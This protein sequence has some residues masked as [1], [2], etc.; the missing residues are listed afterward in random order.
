MAWLNLAVEQ[1]LQAL[2]LF[3]EGEDVA[4]HSIHLVFDC[5]EGQ[6]H[7]GAGAREPV[8]N[9]FKFFEEGVCHHGLAHIPKRPPENTCV[10]TEL[11]L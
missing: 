10:S 8:A 9:D 4:L 7:P 11:M 2:I 3:F 1:A 5:R 6:H